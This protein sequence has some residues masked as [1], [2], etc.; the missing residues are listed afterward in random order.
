MHPSLLKWSWYLTLKIG[1][2]CGKNVTRLFIRIVWRKSALT[3]RLNSG[4]NP[5]SAKN[6]W[7]NSFKVF[8]DNFRK[9]WS[10]N[11]TLSAWNERAEGRRE[12]VWNGEATKAAGVQS[13]QEIE[14]GKPGERKDSELLKISEHVKPSW[15]HYWFVNLEL[16]W[17]V[18][19]ELPKHAEQQV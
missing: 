1:L 13:L 8:C 14:A 10:I 4:K 18:V 19:D 17:R 6:Y 16:F 11:R 5:L 15:W 2:H 9:I 3:W 12:L 7:I